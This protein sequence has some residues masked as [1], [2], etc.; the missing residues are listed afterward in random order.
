MANLNDTLNELKK[1]V[2]SG[3]SIVSCPYMPVEIPGIAFAD[4]FD[5]GDCFGTVATITVPKR[6]IIYSATFWDMDDEG[7]EVDLEVFKYPITQIASDAPWA[8]SDIDLM[9]FITE[10]P[11]ASFRDHGNSRTSE[12]T[13]WGKAYTAPNGKLYI[14]AV[15]ISTPSI[16]IGNLPRFQLQILSGDLDFQEV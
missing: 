13:N 14:Q 1:L 11:F 15:C 2:A 12:V 3:N 8:P 7:T 10:I 6:G 4:A 5:A 9:N 16:A